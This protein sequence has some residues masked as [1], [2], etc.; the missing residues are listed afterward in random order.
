MSEPRTAAL[1]KYADGWRRAYWAHREVPGRHRGECCQDQCWPDI[2]SRVLDD[3]VPKVQAWLA[4]A[5]EAEAASPDSEALRAALEDFVR[6]SDEWIM[7]KEQREAYRI[8]PGEVPPSSFAEK[9][10]LLNSQLVYLRD[11]AHAALNPEVKDE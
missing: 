2:A 5:I 10:L 3:L 8:T 9:A 1:D 7:A 11:R 6:W 4:L